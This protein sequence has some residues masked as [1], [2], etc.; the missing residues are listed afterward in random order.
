MR[1][2]RMMLQGNGQRDGVDMKKRAAEYIDDGAL[3]G[4]INGAI[5][6]GGRGAAISAA[7]GAGPGVGT[8][9]LTRGK[10]EVARSRRV[11]VEVP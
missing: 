9:I 1:E 3:L 11:L 6:G 4:A 5:A 8:Q 7:A 2:Q 10:R